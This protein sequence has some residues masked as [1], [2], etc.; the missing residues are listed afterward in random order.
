M[1]Q[2]TKYLTPALMGLFALQT[3]AVSS[4]EVNSPTY[5]SN[6]N[7]KSLTTPV[8]EGAANNVVFFGVG[9]TSPSPYTTKSDGAAVLGVGVGDPQK[10]LGVQLSLI[11]LDFSAWNTYSASLHVFRD[12]GNAS[13]IGVGVENVMLTNSVDTS[14]DTGKSFYAVYSQ[15]VQADAFVDKAK[16]TSKL[17]YSVGVGSGRFGDKSAVDIATGKGAHGTYVFGNIAYEV[18]H[19]FNVITDWNGLNLNAGVSKTFSIGNFPI[20]VIVGAADLTHNSGDGVRLI[21]VV[22]TGFKL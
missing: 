10:N 1:K 17:H 18:A 7:A 13:S 8:A 5:F 6:S 12:L 21:G 16:G 20:A 14:G 2:F 15:G 3:P 4:A 22:G 11:N 19:S 9:G